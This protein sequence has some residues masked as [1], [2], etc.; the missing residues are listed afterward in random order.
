[1]NDAVSR[2]FAKHLRCVIVRGCTSKCYSQSRALLYRYRQVFDEGDMLGSWG[3]GEL[4]G[5]ALTSVD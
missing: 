4:A 3:A 1:M 5:G 2:R